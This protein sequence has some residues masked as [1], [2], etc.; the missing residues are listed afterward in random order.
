VGLTF[1]PNVSGNLF[2]HDLLK[3]FMNDGPTPGSHPGTACVPVA[4]NMFKERKAE[5]N[6]P[7]MP[8]PRG[9]Q[10]RRMNGPEHVVD[11]ARKQF[12]LVSKMHIEGGTANVGSIQNLL[13]RDFVVWLFLD[14]AAQR[15]M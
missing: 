5:T 15:V 7:L 12:V 2:R 6:Y 8:F 9:C 13:Y 14:Q 1:F 3:V 4:M 10:R 11:A